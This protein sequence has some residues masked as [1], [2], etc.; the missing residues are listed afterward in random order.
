MGK[1]T[2]QDGLNSTIKGQ[3]DE[4]EFIQKCLSLGFK[5]AKPIID[6]G[7]DYIILL[8][9]SWVSVQVKHLG[10]HKP[11]K[12]NSYKRLDLTSGK[13][14]AQEY[15]KNFDFLA[16]VDQDKVWLIPSSELKSR[17]LLLN[18]HMDQYLL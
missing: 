15:T 2:K 5:V 6:I 8:S 16:V 17:Y 3:I 13:Y 7:C 11:N 9:N 14:S 10:N 18:S 4:L 12:K 1:L